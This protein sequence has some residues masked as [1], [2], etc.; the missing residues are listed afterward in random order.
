MFN[1]CLLIG[2]HVF[3]LHSQPNFNNINP[4]VYCDTG[5]FI[6]GTYLNSE[7]KQSVYIGKNFQGENFGLMIGGVTGYVKKITPAIVPSFRL[8]IKKDLYAKSF[9]LLPAYKNAPI[10]VSF[11]IEYKF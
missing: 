11:S 4:G 2:L 8:E 1:E 9:L 10:G 5:N 6:V 7:K 3:S